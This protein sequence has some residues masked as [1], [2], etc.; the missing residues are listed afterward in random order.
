MRPKSADCPCS[1]EQSAALRE[2]KVAQ[3]KKKKKNL[4]F[5][6]AFSDD[7]YLLENKF[8]VSYILYIKN[9]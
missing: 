7:Y 5:K 3:F 9:I 2:F 6:S 1:T 8:I 4:R